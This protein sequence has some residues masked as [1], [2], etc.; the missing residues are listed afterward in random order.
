M[1]T[2]I[3]NGGDG[4][5]YAALPSGA[6]Y[7]GSKIS[8]P[9]VSALTGEIIQKIPMSYKLISEDKKEHKESK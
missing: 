9:V 1:A 8:N 5:S 3:A 2:G 6:T 4:L 7:V